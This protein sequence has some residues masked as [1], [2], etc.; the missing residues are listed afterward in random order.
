MK[1]FV[2]AV[3]AIFRTFVVPKPL[4]KAARLR[5]K[6]S[7]N[8]K[9]LAQISP[10]LFVPGYTA[11]VGSRSILIPFISKFLCAMGR[12]SRRLR[13]LHFDEAFSRHASANDDLCRD[14]V[15]PSICLSRT[16]IQAHLWL[17]LTNG[18]EDLQ[19]SRRL[20][21]LGTESDSTWDEPG[22]SRPE[23]LQ[24]PVEIFLEA[25]PERSDDVLRCRQ[26][27]DDTTNDLTQEIRDEHDLDEILFDLYDAYR[28]GQSAG[29]DAT[30]NQP[31][32]WYNVGQD[33]ASIGLVEKEPFL[34]SEVGCARANDEVVPLPPSQPGRGIVELNTDF[35]CDMSSDINSSNRPTSSLETQMVSNGS[36]DELAVT[37]IIGGPSAL[38]DLVI[39]LLPHPKRLNHLTC[40]HSPSTASSHDLL[41]DGI[42][43]EALSEDFS[44]LS[45]QDTDLNCENQTS[46]RASQEPPETLM[47][48]EATMDQSRSQ[49]R[50][51][52]SAILGDEH[53]MW[54]MWQ[55]RTSVAPVPE[56]AIELHHMF[57]EDPD[58]KLLGS[59][60]RMSRALVTVGIDEEMLDTDYSTNGTNSPTSPPAGPRKMY[61]DPF[62][63]S[64][65]KSVERPTSSRSARPAPPRRLSRGSS[66]LK[67][68]SLSSRSSSGAG[69]ASDIDMQRVED[70]LNDKR[71][72]VEIKRRKNLEDYR[73]M[74]KDGE[75]DEMMLS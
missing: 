34:L 14:D 75:I 6:E 74:E 69:S 41:E 43:L 30:Q 45:V 18:L 4:S 16:K 72:P 1:A 55:R 42:I 66:F 62:I 60:R 24:D 40:A 67:R 73:D 2:A 33:E 36:F 15:S 22:Y 71:R 21:P 29:P 32:L 46:S 20:R 23:S 64:P 48:H 52:L 7:P 68:L 54:H 25:Y 38:T 50:D 70:F 37:S 49:N 53:L 13:R 57:A 12:R 58:M 5:M 65:Q 28:Q 31:N 56:D 8:R 11:Q 26:F 44:I 59:S 63:P 61:S 27:A 19:S 39:R 3:D 10:A 47:L 17:T 9:C 51:S 35:F